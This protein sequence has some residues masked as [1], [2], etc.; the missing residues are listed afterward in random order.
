METALWESVAALLANQLPGDCGSPPTSNLAT[1]A[2][3]F[4]AY[5]DINMAHPAVGALS[6]PVKASAADYLLGRLN[7]ASGLRAQPAPINFPRISTL[8]PDTYSADQIETLRRWF[9]IEPANLLRLM[10]VSSE[11]LEAA[12]R[13]ITVAFKRLHQCAPEL[14]D[15]TQVTI[16]DIIV[17]LPGAET[18]LEL[19]GVSSFALWGALAINPDTQ[20]VDGWVHYFKTIVHEA[21]HNVLFA[22]ARTEPFVLNDINSRYS[23][24]LRSDPRPMDGIF[25]AAF[26]SAR[27]S[28]AFSRLLGWHEDG[29]GLTDAEI[30]LSEDFLEAGVIAFWQCSEILRSEALLSPLG[31]AILSDCEKFMRDEFDLITG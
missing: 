22:F 15:E 27:E 2:L 10:P 21:G 3:D 31:D 19:G 7:P 13:E 16:R 18:G 9:D 23:S 28:H 8:A 24:P 5:F 14:H 25:H 26:V 11:R 12:E 30:V 29:G 1:G 6:D 17:A 20:D 4:G